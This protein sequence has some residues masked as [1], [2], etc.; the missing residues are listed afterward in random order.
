MD[1]VILLSR[2]TMK[3]ITPKGS[4]DRPSKD[5]NCWCAPE[6][7]HVA[8]FMERARS[9]QLIIELHSIFAYSRE[10]PPTWIAGNIRKARQ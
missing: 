6:H 1:W 8:M 10:N 3:E 4:F 7:Y 2:T 5:P 9:G